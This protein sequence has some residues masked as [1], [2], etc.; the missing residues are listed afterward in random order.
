[1]TCTK[2]AYIVRAA[3]GDLAADQPVRIFEAALR[4]VVGPKMTG[5][6]IAL[7]YTL[8]ANNKPGLGR[9]RLKLVFRE[10]PALIALEL[11]D[12][13]PAL[14]GGDPYNTMKAT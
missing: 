4:L 8:R 12:A 9:G 1:V 5:Q 7:R 10:A 2:D 13:V 11:E 6:K 14:D 3:L